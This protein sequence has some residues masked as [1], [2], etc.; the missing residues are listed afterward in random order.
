MHFQACKQG[1]VLKNK[2]KKEGRA[3]KL[4]T[5]NQLNFSFQYYN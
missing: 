4:V 2:A 1:T 5:G 3:K